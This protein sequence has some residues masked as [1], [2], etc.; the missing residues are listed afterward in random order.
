MAT[1]DTSTSRNWQHDGSS[2]GV[3]DPVLAR[4]F[5]PRQGHR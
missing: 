1:P 3:P 4:F 2:A 5:L